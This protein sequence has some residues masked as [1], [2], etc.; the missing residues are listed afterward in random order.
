MHKDGK[1]KHENNSMLQVTP[2]ISWRR[3]SLSCLATGSYRVTRHVQIRDVADTL[4]ETRDR[5]SDNKSS[6]EHVGSS[7]ID[8]RNFATPDSGP[9]TA[10][11]ADNYTLID[12]VASGHRPVRLRRACYVQP[13]SEIINDSLGSQSA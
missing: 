10:I 12:E 2:K 5:D 6:L 9:P 7:Q 11:D 3:F 4:W 8:S 1:K 13:F